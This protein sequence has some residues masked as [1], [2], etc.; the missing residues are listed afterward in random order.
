MKAKEFLNK[1]YHNKLFTTEKII[2]DK[3]DTLNNYLL[4]K[5][6]MQIQNG[7]NMVTYIY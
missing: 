5:M 2:K 4:R 3:Y 7:I 6:I 1:T